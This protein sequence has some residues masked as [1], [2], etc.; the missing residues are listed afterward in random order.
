MALR[1]INKNFKNR[2]KDIKY[3]NKDF[4]QFKEN[5]VEYARTYFPKAY[6]DFSDLQV[7]FL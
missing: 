5:L 2:G 6:N 1:S 7:L 3:L 4:S